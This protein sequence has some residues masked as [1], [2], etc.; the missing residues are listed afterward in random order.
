[1]AGIS[2]R[3]ASSLRNK[4]GI[5][6]KEIQNKEFSDGGGLDLYDFNARLYDHQTGHF[7]AIDPHAIKFP[8]LSPYVY[9]AD[10]PINCIDPDGKEW[11]EVNG[12]V[13]WDD[14][15]AD[16]K[17]AI[18]YYGDKAVYRAPG[19]EWEN[20]S[21]G[22]IT[23]GKD[24]SYTVNGESKIAL[25]A[26][27]TAVGAAIMAGGFDTFIEYFEKLG[28]DYFFN[29]ANRDF[30]DNASGLMAY[31][32][33]NMAG[34]SDA[35]RL[36]QMTHSWVDAGAGWTAERNQLEHQIGMFLVAEKYGEMRAR[37][38]GMLNEYRGLII[39]DRQSGRMLDAILGRG[40][41]AFEWT[42]IMHNMEGIDKWK[43]YHGMYEVKDNKLKHFI[44]DDFRWD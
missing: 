22:C 28:V 16:L 21:Y 23:L 19:Y 17:T 41:T 44:E 9:V 25:N 6:G 10:N 26:T 29:A 7:P 14:R 18:Q 2:N 27:P 42:D 37:N 43:K 24:M 8:S 13:I 15:V 34:V 32:K 5:T 4:Y 30:N 11:V 38:I 20:K 31:M 3:A 39:N 35:I 33:E 40:G 1:M 36:S 12:K